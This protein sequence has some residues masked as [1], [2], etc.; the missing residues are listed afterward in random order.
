MVTH[1]SVYDA[2]A[3]DTIDK[4]YEHYMSGLSASRA[5]AMVQRRAIEGSVA[6][7][8]WAAFVLLGDDSR[9]IFLRP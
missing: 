2:H 7:M 3:Q 8:D 4:F 5:L 9:S 1:W 6:P